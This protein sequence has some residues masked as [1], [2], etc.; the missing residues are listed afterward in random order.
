[1]GDLHEGGYVVVDP[2]DVVKEGV[3][4]Q[5]AVANKQGGK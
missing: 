1:V 3:I 4:V 5:I 2:G